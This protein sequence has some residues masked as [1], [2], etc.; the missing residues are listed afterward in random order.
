MTEQKRPRRL[1]VALAG[2]PNSGKTS[3]FN[4]LTG[5]HQ[6]VGNWPGVTV[7]RKTGRVDYRGYQIEVVDLP[8]T[9][10]LSP[11][12]IEERIAREY[13]MSE[14][15]DV[16]V[17]V[18]DAANLSRNLY[19]TVQLLE[20]G[21]DVVVDLNMWDEFVSSGAKLDL[22]AFETLLGTP[23]ATTVGHKGEGREALLD[24][25]ID[26][27]ENR[28]ERH[29]HV[30]VSYGPHIERLLEKLEAV[31]GEDCPEK[32]GVP[33]RYIAVKLLEGD[34]HI[35]QLVHNRLG[36]EGV[37][38]LAEDLRARLQRISK[39]DP[40]VAI[41]EARHGFV[42]GLLR[43]V[44]RKPRMDRMEFSRQLDRI[45]TNRIL[46]LPI[47]LLFM[48]LLFNGTFVL[49]R[50]PMM[51][52][53]AATSWLSGVAA[54]LLPEGMFQDLVV[55]GVLGGVGAVAAFLPNIVLL[56]LGI[57][58][59]ED[60][61]YMARAAFIMDRLMH[62]L[63]LHGKSF[64]PMLMGFGCSVPA[65][66]ATR[67]L[68]SRRDRILTSLLVPLMS[69]SARLPI[70]VL[71]AGTFFGRSAGNVILGIYL[72]GM[73]AAILVGRLFSKTLFAG[74]EAPFVMELPPYRWPT[75]RGL[76]LHMWER[77]KH[78]LKKMGGV[79]LVASVVLW[80]LS[81]FPLHPALGE[82]DA[83][84]EQMKAAGADEDEIAHLEAER[85]ALA[86]EYSVIGRVGK[87]AAHVL[88]PLGFDWRMSVALITG[89][90]AK[91]VVVSSL[92]VL[93][94]V[95]SSG[96]EA[97][98]AALADPTNGVT[99]L[100]ALAFMVFALLYTPCVVSVLT[101]RREFGSKWMWFSVGYQTVLAWAFA[102]IVYQGGRLLGLG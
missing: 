43:E 67:M 65:I 94:N 89:F 13:I 24:A 30:P 22:E 76:L 78:Y 41:S 46:G 75:S 97:L 28:R 39:E 66:M 10:S 53:E 49:G 99:P 17:D 83:R 51:A 47:F 61:G 74:E 33:A 85:S 9:Y 80:G 27:A 36:G 63:G 18:V 38:H 98:S 21:V 91:E 59:L 69:C 44:Y 8:G 90:V 5:L 37:I 81:T 71:F 20:M 11:F 87:A 35:V 96:S 60:S 64:I 16:V 25:I 72:V 56:F 100:A 34:P 31:I 29:R 2:N 58:I 95:G 92:A 73:L 55:E 42:D 50:Y 102:L 57:A 40:G 84:I 62:I 82:Y 93:Y 68:E 4:L 26:L 1:R 14:R 52:I 15:P 48:W 23:V 6:Q 32:L 101:M 7:E 45:L 19:L 54:A 77:A 3:V 86:I 79:I 12:S 88:S 70:Y